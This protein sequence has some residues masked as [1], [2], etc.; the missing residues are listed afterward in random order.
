[1]KLSVVDDRVVQEPKTGRYKVG[2]DHINCV[3]TAC[4]E[5]SS[6][7][8]S[9]TKPQKPVQR[10]ESPGRVLRN[11][12]VCKDEDHGVAGENPVSAVNMLAID[13]QPKSRNNFDNS[14]SHLSSAY[15]V[16]Q[17]WITKVVRVSCGKDGDDHRQGP[18]PVQQ[19]HYQ[20]HT[21]HQNKPVFVQ[22]DSEGCH[23][24]GKHDEDL[25][26]VK[27]PSMVGKTVQ[28]DIWK[29]LAL[30]SPQFV[31]DGKGGGGEDEV[32]EDEEERHAGFPPLNWELSFRRSLSRW[33]LYFY[34][35]C[36]SISD[37]S[38]AGR[39]NLPTT[40]P[41][42]TQQGLSLMEFCFFSHHFCLGCFCYKLGLVFDF[43]GLL[44]VS[45]GLYRKV[46]SMWIASLMKMCLDKSIVRDNF[47][48]MF[49]LT[50]VGSI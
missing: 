32:E 37:S 41:L 10:P 19:A 7:A 9:C 23:K 45:L 21:S 18:V 16:V 50:Q 13:A 49:C 8:N 4:N 30:R 6:N 47:L 42:I 33:K 29:W 3:V 2:N 14:V 12:Q 48:R 26:Y 46:E 20:A 11:N 27:S 35:D 24:C 31:G 44:F 17:L 5:Q 15:C 38:W 22:Q 34:F 36:R 28:G 1:M 40:N 39:P 43:I 25:G